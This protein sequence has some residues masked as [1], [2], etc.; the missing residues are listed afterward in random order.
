MNCRFTIHLQTGILPRF[1]IQWIVT[2]LVHGWVTT[3]IKR[4]C[5]PNHQCPV[6][7]ALR[8]FEAEKLMADSRRVVAS[9]VFF[10]NCQLSTLFHKWIDSFYNSFKN[11]LVIYSTNHGTMG[12]YRQPGGSRIL[13]AR[14]GVV[15]GRSDLDL[16][17]SSDVLGPSVI[18]FKFILKSYD[19][20]YVA[21]S[22]NL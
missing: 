7:E 2:S 15:K 4:S 21:I 9:R 22:A 12:L 6:F 16:I 14:N 3:V 18:Q 10:R 8:A 19:T 11:T 17:C 13:K 20:T 1:S 5:F